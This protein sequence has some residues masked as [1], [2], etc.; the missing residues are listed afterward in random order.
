MS[1][2]VGL[3]NFAVF[4]SL[5]FHLPL[6]FT[7]DP[8][9]I[10]IV[11]KVLPTL[12]GVQIFDGLAASAHGLLRGIGRQAIGG[13]VNLIA[14]YVISLPISLAMAFWLDWKLDGLWVG[15]AVGLIC[16]AVFEYIYL[17]RTDW[18]HASREA[19]RRNQ[20]G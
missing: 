18:H 8:E 13:P 5:R 11:A 9:V 4:S 7:N 20:A 1:I 17:L 6:L 2:I 15:V 3:V 19:A 16:V 12:A 14:Y 10:A